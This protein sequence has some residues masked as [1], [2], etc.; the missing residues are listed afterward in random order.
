MPSYEFSCLTC[1]RTFERSLPMGADQ[2]GVRCPAGHQ[3]VRRI[4]TA[5]P[6]F[7]KGSGFYVTDH[8]SDS[9]REPGS[10]S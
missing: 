2:V 3:R 7:F 10:Q 8:P 1:G 4:Y 9:H 6:V 5:A